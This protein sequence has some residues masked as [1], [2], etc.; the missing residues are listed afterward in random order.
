M[1]RC[2]GKKEKPGKRNE[3]TCEIGDRIL[4]LKGGGVCED[5][6]KELYDEK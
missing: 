1:E 4:S 2:C 6:S 5:S 3:G